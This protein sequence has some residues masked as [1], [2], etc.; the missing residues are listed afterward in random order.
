MTKLIRLEAE[1]FKRLRAV[2]IRPSEQGVTVVAGRN[3]Q[4]K[5]SVLDAIQSA[6][7][8]KRSAPERPVRDGED[9]AVIVCE[10]DGG[11]VVRRS[12][13][14]KGGGSL[15]VTAADGADMRS[16]QQVLDAMFATMAFDPLAFTRMSSKEQAEEVRRVT[17]LDLSDL[18][19]RHATAYAAR[20]DANREVK[21]LQGAVDS[22]PHHHDAESV[23]MD[24]LYAERSAARDSM[25]LRDR[26]QRR[27]DGLRAEH[28]EVREKIRVL[29]ERAEALVQEAR[30]AKQALADM[31]PAPDLADVEK[32]IATADAQA[33]KVRENEKRA[34][35]VS[36]LNEAQAQAKR[37]DDEIQ[38][39][40]AERA[41]RIASVDLP[42][43]GLEFDGDGVTLHGMPYS[44]A[45]SAEQL[46]ASMA[47][48]LASNPDL[49]LVLIRD[50][51]LLDADSLRLVAEMAADRD[52]QV[53]VE[54]VGTED[55][56]A[57]VIE[58]GSVAEGGTA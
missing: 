30:D 19:D 20:R 39:V 12:F 3:A 57:I 50:G 25:D 21:R 1:N 36:K 29:T 26:T 35:L 55:P 56:A 23:D 49:R 28:D 54:R 52:A 47:L 24:A 17:G 45:S 53:L 7:A 5:S 15:T 32:R 33:R 8:G 40:A 27:L 14:A 2:E 58:D 37:H 51:S 4:G 42:V 16:P 10:L 22:V 6:L 31:P 18:D 38:S 9:K 46:R 48:G 34:A 11:L 13:T 44:Q 43:P 41:S